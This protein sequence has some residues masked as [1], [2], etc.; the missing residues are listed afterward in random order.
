MSYK[1]GVCVLCGTGCAHFL[2]TD[3]ERVTGVAPSLGHP[4]SEGKLCHRGW[5]SHRTE[6][7]ERRITAPLL[8]DREGVLRP[9][10]SYDE[11]ISGL[12]ERVAELRK[13]GIVPGI[14]APASLSNEDGYLLGKLARTVLGARVFIEGLEPGYLESLE[15]L[16]EILG[17]RGAIGRFEELDRCACLLVLEN[18]LAR[19]S[20]ILEGKVRRAAKRGA[21][22]VYV[23]GIPE[24]ADELR[25]LP[26]ASSVAIVFVAE[27]FGRERETVRAIA[28]LAQRTGK[29]G[30]D[31][32][33]LFPLAATPG[34]QQG[35]V[36]MGL[37]E[38]FAG[39]VPVLA[40]GALWTPS[41]EQ[42]EVIFPIAKS[43]EAEAS[44]TA[45]DRRVQLSPAKVRPPAGVLPAWRLCAEIARKAG[46]GWSFE[47]A[48]GVFDELAREVPGYSGLSHATLARGFGAHWQHT[49]LRE[50]QTP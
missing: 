49:A 15:A 3:G 30:R 22:V 8:R 26:E 33:G 2:R 5:R 29:M 10:S 37:R 43:I 21:R 25:R 23:S 19:V 14:L 18:E 47:Q 28:Q 20:P 9:A 45:S 36:D 6:D 38:R 24:L 40:L 44:F 34:N 42:A 50:G 17:V 32:S 7:R 11:A 46:Q 41:M 13:Q 39:T 12:L 16:H 4:V 27:E 35:L 31:G 48:S 1:A